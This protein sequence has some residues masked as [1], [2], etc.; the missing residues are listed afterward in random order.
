MN[1]AIVLRCRPRVNGAHCCSLLSHHASRTATFLSNAVLQL[2]PHSCALAGAYSAVPPPASVQKAAVAP[3]AAKAKK[4]D[5]SDSSDDSSDEEEKKIASK[6]TPTVYG[7]TARSEDVL[8]NSCIT[9]TAKPAPKAAP[10]QPVVSKAA[11]K[12]QES[13]SESSGNSLWHH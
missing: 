5:S 13:S 7:V 3:A 9:S 4:S 6:R 8:S 2:N 10:A 11:A 12:K 1:C